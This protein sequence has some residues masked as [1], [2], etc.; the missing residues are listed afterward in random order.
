MKKQ[1]IE[2]LICAGA[3]DC[4]QV[5][6][7]TMRAQYS[8]WDALTAKEREELPNLTGTLLEQIRA[9]V[10]ESTVDERKKAKR[11]VPN[12]RRR[13]K[14]RGLIQDFQDE[15]RRDTVAQILTWEKNYLGATLS[16]SMADLNRAMSGAQ[17]TCKQI[18]TGEIQPGWNVGLCVV[19]EGVREVTVK[20]G[21]TQGRQMAFVT[22]SDSTYSLDGS[23]IFPDSYDQMKLDGIT[24]GDVVSIAGKMS[25][26]GL[27]INRMR[28]LEE[29]D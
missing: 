18:G 19:V 16:G 9:L 23:C 28:L 26:R 7:R 11:R 10:D 8:L 20:R 5:S 21:K 2:A 13:E 6:R 15:A 17:H 1:V 29:H 4:F 14:I 12:V 24:E 25:D 22:V 3:L 27:I